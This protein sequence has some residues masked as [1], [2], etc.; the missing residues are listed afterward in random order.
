[1]EEI[2][3]DAEV[4]IVLRSIHPNL[5]TEEQTGPRFKLLTLLRE[6]KSFVRTEVLL[7]SKFFADVLLQDSRI[8]R[9][10]KAIELKITAR[11]NQ[12]SAESILAC[13]DYLSTDDVDAIDLNPETMLSILVSSVFL[14]LKILEDHV[15]KYIASQLTPQSIVTI[16][17]TAI[18]AGHKSLQ[19]HCYV[20]IKQ[21]LLYRLGLMQRPS[22]LESEDRNLD[23][24]NPTLKYLGDTVSLDVFKDKE[25][26]SIEE[27]MIYHRPQNCY[28]LMRI[29]RSRTDDTISGSDYP[30]TF[31][32]I[33]EHTGAKMMYAERWSDSSDIIIC[34]S[35]GVAYS[36]Q[37]LGYITN[38]FW[39][40]GFDLY[41]HGVDDKVAKRLPAG[42][43]KKREH[44]LK[45]HYDTN[46][47]GDNPRSL[48]CWLVDDAT[49]TKI[50]FRNVPPRWNERTECYTLNFY[51]R[52]SR[53]SA[54]NFQL[55]M[56]EDP[57]T[58]YLMF[59]KIGRD[60]FHLDYRCPFSMFQAFAIA[61]CSL[62]RKRVVA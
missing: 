11:K 50:E 26:A 15:A 61:L 7:K 30:H 57:N 24:V 10:S 1:M 18:Q 3:L 60:S 37:Y 42:F 36:E 53:A 5:K 40:N 8:L 2:P 13:L 17:K 23:F 39:G 45:V 29:E 19:H 56:P 48:Q 16:L 20:W 62:A 6:F 34:K 41:D 25:Q 47:L 28:N 43:V 27:T 32:L 46:I 58:I 54:K 49:Q 44:K 52:V 33:H 31:T 59:G 12:V 22:S 9:E 38:N 35:E 14:K 4:E 21:L 55:V 51:G